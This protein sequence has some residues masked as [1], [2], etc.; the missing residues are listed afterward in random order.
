MTET[1]DVVII[2][3][4][5]AGLGAAIKLEE[6]GRD[7]FVILDD[8]LEVGGTWRDNTYPGA[9]CDIPS[10][11]YSY[12]FD[13]NPDWSFAYAK[14]E[15]I[16]RYIV[17]VSHRHGLRPHLR[18][19]RRVREARWSED[20]KRWEVTTESGETYRARICIAGVGGLRDPAYPAIEGRE[21]FA[22]PSMHSA[23]W[24]HDVD[25]ANKRVGVIGT[26]ASAIQ[27][28]PAI[29][30]EASEVVLF[31]RTPP[32]VF[33]RWDRSYGPLRKRLYRH[34]PW[35]QRLH[36]AAIYGRAESRFVFFGPLGEKLSPPIQRL[37]ER[38]VASQVRDPDKRD[39]LIPD[40]RMGCKRMLISD[41]YY[42]ALDRD[43]V[44][45][46]V[47]APDA[48]GLRGDVA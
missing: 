5:F 48:L 14:G 47:E 29:A 24:D 25:L 34:L 15:E 40:Y 44:S 33:P 37:A 35:L 39:K 9:A 23:R 20:D 28:V 10:H 27:V 12:S 19:G 4:G 11:L 8:G 1:L 22:G 41:D 32:W 7:D 31:Q 26:G 16:Q 18:L 13:L 21:R 42:Q 38:F 30:P 3:A 2:G 46:E 43:D 45:L 6:A 17:A 36:R